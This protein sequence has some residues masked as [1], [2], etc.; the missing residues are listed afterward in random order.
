[1][2]RAIMDISAP[3]FSLPDI[4]AR[5]SHQV[6]KNCGSPHREY[7]PTKPRYVSNTRSAP[8]AANSN[9]SPQ[10]CRASNRAKNPS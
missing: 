10:Y 2:L 4:V 9:A 8:S 7:R 6:R 3:A 5:L 1:V